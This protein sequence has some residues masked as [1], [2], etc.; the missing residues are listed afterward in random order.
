MTSVGGMLDVIIRPMGEDDLDQV[1]AIDQISFSLPWAKRAF[2]YE[3]LENPHSLL[4]VA[5]LDCKVVGAIVV[6]IILDEAHISTLAVLPEHRLQGY[7]QKLV[8]KAL[9]S[10]VESGAQHATLEVRASNIA[11]QNLYRGFGF[12]IVGRRPRYYQDNQEDALIMTL[13][14]LDQKIERLVETYPAQFP[15]NK[16]SAR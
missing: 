11:A 2:R 3:L 1:H 5:E 14:D 12:E 4:W 15:G 8:V 6:W 16:S 9:S 10:A 7:A 13:T